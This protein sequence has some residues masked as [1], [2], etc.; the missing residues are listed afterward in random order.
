MN[1][2]E[3]KSLIVTDNVY[4]VNDKFLE[5]GRYYFMIIRF[6]DKNTVLGQ[7]L[8]IDNLVN[9]EYE[10]RFFSLMNMIV[11]GQSYLARR[12][13]TNLLSNSLKESNENMPNYPSPKKPCPKRISKLKENNKKST[14]M[15]CLKDSDNYDFSY[16]KL[17]CGHRFHFN[18]IK[19]WKCHCNTCPICRKE[20]SEQFLIDC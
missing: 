14:C 10:F 7:I 13:D 5:A 9:A 12:V 19:E 1:G 18:C 17:K 3:M 15:I 6:S 8:S 2:L 16:I 11:K 4:D 20:L